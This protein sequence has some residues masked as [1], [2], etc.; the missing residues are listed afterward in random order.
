MA[1]IR[2]RNTGPERLVRSLL[3]RAGFRFRLHRRDLPGSPDIVLPRHRAVV[4]VHGCFWHA[5]PGCPLAK[6]PTSNAEFWHRKLLANRERDARAVEALLAA[7]W[8]VLV[9]W[10]CGLRGRKEHGRLARFLAS[11]VAGR[12]RRAEYPRPRRP[13]Q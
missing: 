13:G 6:E 10:E 4:F 2:G 9:V 11:W 12:G 3:H 7:G 1:G 5:H 8:R